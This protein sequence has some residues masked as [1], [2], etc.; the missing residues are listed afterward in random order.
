M[1][2]YACRWAELRAGMNGLGNF[3][4]SFS[5]GP[6]VPKGLV[7]LARPTIEDPESFESGIVT[8]RGREFVRRS[9]AYDVTVDGRGWNF[10]RATSEGAEHDHDG[11]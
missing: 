3:Y 1:K 7:R 10:V 5:I 11:C 4:F 6:Q 8:W 9:K 2:T